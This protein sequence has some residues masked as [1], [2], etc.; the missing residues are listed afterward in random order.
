[1]AVSIGLAALTLRL[2][3]TLR[4]SRVRRKPRARGL[5]ERHLALAKPTV[6]MVLVGFAAGPISAV[7]LRGMEGLE[8]FTGVLGLLCAGLFTATAVIG[9]RIERGQARAFAVHGLLGLLAVLAAALAAV[10]GFVLL[11]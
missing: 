4:R 3:L 8:S 6:A 11:A 9:R 10:A 5:R 2:G 7:W 1:M